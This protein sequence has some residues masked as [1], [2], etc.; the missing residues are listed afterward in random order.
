ML[1]RELGRVGE[2]TPVLSVAPFTLMCS[3]RGHQW[4][5]ASGCY[6]PL[7]TIAIEVLSVFSPSF[8][9]Y[10]LLGHVPQRDPLDRALVRLP[11][12]PRRP[13]ARFLLTSPY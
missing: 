4:H 10:Y 12:P 2:T 3:R 9:H 6:C 13:R 1:S 11:S 5:F 7:L 8:Q